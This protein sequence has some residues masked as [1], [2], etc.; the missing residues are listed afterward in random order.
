MARQLEIERRLVAWADWR[1]AFGCA[2]ATQES[3]LSADDPGP[4]SAASSR[5]MERL[6]AM[7]PGDLQETITEFYVHDGQVSD[8]VRRL[9]RSE[10]ILVRR[11]G[12]AHLLLA[13]QLDDARE[14]VLRERERTLIRNW[15]NVESS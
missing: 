12:R 15:L 11:I 10:T 6:V 5:E 14:L 2:D 3:A 9:G 1:R 7:L 4:G 8:H 13:W